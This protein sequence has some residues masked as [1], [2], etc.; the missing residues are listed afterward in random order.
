MQDPLPILV[1]GKGER[2]LGIVARHAQEWNMWASA[3]TLRERSS[4]LARQCEAIGRD[5]ATIE[6][7]VQAIVHVTDDVSAAQAV[8][9][10]VAPRPVFAGPAERFADMVAEW[11]EAGAT[12]IVVPDFA[13]SKGQQRLDDMD[14]LLAAGRS[15]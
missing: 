4:V 11:A 8:I 5:P 7:S 13:M 3:E 6:R 9:E 12:E 15:V 1:G 10:A 2:M 14:A